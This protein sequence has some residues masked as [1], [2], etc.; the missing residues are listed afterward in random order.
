[1]T[2]DI[3]LLS[4]LSTEQRSAFE[5]RFDKLKELIAQDGNSVSVE[6]IDGEE[7]LV[8]RNSRSEFISSEPL[9]VLID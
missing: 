3:K 9:Q 2:I 5:A 8:Y 6:E 7:K 1:M 4:Q